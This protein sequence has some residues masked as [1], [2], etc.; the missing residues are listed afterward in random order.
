M[1]MEQ[2]VKRMAAVLICAALLAIPA[3]AGN[4][5]ALPQS[6]ENCTP[7]LRIEQ[8]QAFYAWKAAI[9]GNI[10]NSSIAFLEEKAGGNGTAQLEGHAL[11]YRQ[12]SD[13]T[14]NMTDPKEIREIAKEMRDIVR[15]FRAELK[16]Q[17][18]AAH[19]N[20]GELRERGN[21]GEDRGRSEVKFSSGNAQ[22]KP[23]Q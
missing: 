5:E 13:A 7:E 12:K 14:L 18:R 1:G 2:T 11:A 10:M 6:G 8:M 21:H 17:L 3:C 16:D 22:G 23:G 9:Q 20:M 4:G 15:Q 19:S